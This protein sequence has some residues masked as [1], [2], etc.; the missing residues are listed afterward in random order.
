V[1][2]L[3]SQ[4]SV[5]VQINSYDRRAMTISFVKLVRQI[6][7]EGLAPA[8]AKLDQIGAGKPVSL[9]FPDHDSANHFIRSLTEIG[10]RAVVINPLTQV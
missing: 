1:E 6:T 10:F 9:G 7:G 2:E 4:M 8:K 3:L 5:T